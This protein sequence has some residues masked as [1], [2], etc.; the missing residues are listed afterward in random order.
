MECV[1]ES[2]PRFD[3]LRREGMREA[4]E[5]AAML[6]LESLGWGVRRRSRVQV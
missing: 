4:D 5:V 1:N 2:S 3:E 6:R